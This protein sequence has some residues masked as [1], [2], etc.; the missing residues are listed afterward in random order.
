[1]MKIFLVFKTHFD[2]GFTDY[3]RNV[4]LQYQT[5]MLP[6]VIDTCRKTAGMGE[7]KYV[8]TMPAWPLTVMRANPEF[9]RELEQLIQDGQIAWHALPYTSHFDFCGLEDFI[10][11]FHYAADLSRAYHRPLPVSAK[12]TDV[13]GHGRAL[14]TLLSA[15][16]IRFLHLGCNAFSTPPDVPPLFFWEGMDGSRVLTMYSAGGYGSQLLPPKEWPFPVWMALMHTH[17]NTGPQSADMIRAMVAEARQSCPDAEI[18]CGTMDDFYRELAAC[19]LSGLP[20]VRKDLA[21]SWIHGAGT[22]PSEV[23]TVRQARRDLLAANTAAF[24]SGADRESLREVNDRAYGA[25]ALFDEHTW[26]MDVKTFMDPD[27]VY[28]KDLFQKALSTEE[29]RHIEASWEEQRQRAVSAGEDARRALELS[30]TPGGYAVLNPNGCAFSGWADAEKDVPPAVP[31][32][33]GYK[34]YVENVPPVSACPLPVVNSAEGIGGGLEN[35][36]YRLMVDAQRGII[37]ELYD[38]KLSRPL[39]KERDGVG[40]FSYR[41]D[42]Y[43]ISEGTEYLR[44]YAYRFFDWGIRDN[45]KDGYPEIEH[46]TCQPE[47]LNMEQR[48]HTVVLR[49]RGTGCE[50]YGDAEIIRIEVSLPP[51]GDELFLHAVLEKKQETPYTESAC[52]AFPL[53]EDAPSYRVNKNGNLLDPAVE[54]AP[55]ANHA[56]Y[57]VEDFLCAE[58]PDYGMCL[59]SRD[60]P[61]FS[62]GETGIYTYRK[63]YEEHAPILYCGLFNNMWGTNFPQWI[64]GDFD[65]RFTMFGYDGSADGALYGRALALAQGARVLP[66]AP[67]VSGLQLPEGVQVMNF[68]PEESGWVLHLRDTALTARSVTLRFPGRKITPVDLRGTPLG[69]SR[70]DAVTVPVK[71]FGVLAFRM[72]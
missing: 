32:P 61:L 39:L 10:Y 59:I 48:D 11:G 7:L 56:L 69:P 53:A 65:Y 46:Q 19:D 36:R 38:K 12:M 71:P 57:C 58:G 40:V 24:L 67:A 30:G 8:W 2:I 34:V 33:D 1:M 42:I 14:P 20:V 52:I 45:M 9:R 23:Q 51:M 41:Y 72:E 22:Y 6:D 28:R 49:Y 18:V 21:D 13:P 25:L 60:A 70:T 44:N 66:A 17:D 62:I 4:I 68:L 35:R 27:R 43:G 26:G 64:G 47:F 29:Y 3:A 50:P 55:Q 15:A 54:I 37:T 31:F 16:G 63:Q 5:K